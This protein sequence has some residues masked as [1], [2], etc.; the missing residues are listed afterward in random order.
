MMSHDELMQEMYSEE[1]RDDIRFEAAFELAEMELSALREKRGL[2]QT[3]VAER[4]Q[5]AQPRLSQIENSED[6]YLS[7]LK[8]YVEAL[9]GELAVCVT[10][11]DDEDQVRISI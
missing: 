4:M 6:Y 9:G 8:R 1:E 11:E 10:F 3:E 5:T 7:T 2:T